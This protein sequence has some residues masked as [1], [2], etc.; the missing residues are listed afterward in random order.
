MYE[1]AFKNMEGI[2]LLKVLPNSKH[3]RHLFTILVDPEKR[4]NTLWELQSKGIAVAV[5]YKA[6][7]LLTYYKQHY[8][9][10]RGMFPVAE[11]MGDS[12]ITLPLYPKL[13]DEEVGYVIQVVKKVV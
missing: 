2:T 5:N 12:T 11:R 8:G 10:E 9:Y 13:S 4:D 6:V 1:E 3:A 7:H